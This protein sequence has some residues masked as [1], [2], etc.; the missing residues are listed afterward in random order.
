MSR[1]A[2]V[3]SIHGRRH[4]Q[5]VAVL[6]NGRA[7]GVTER[8]RR[9]I[10]RFVPEQD[11]FYS[12]S[13][14]E[15]RLVTRRI[16]DEGYDVV[17]AGGGD[18]TF[19]HCVNAL[20]EN[21]GDADR[22]TTP[23]GAALQLAPR[24][25]PRL[26]VLRL[27]TGN[28]LASLTGAGTGAVGAVED[29]L[30]V[31]SG[32]ARRTL[33]LHLLSADGTLTPFAGV[34]LD[35]R[36]LSDYVRLRD[37][38]ERTPLAMLGTGRAG[39]LLSVAGLSLPALLRQA[40]PNVTITNEGADAIQLGPDGRAVGRPIARG[41]VLYAGPARFCA[42][43]TEPYYGYGFAA[44]PHALKA[45]GFMQLR[46]TSLGVAQLVRHLPALWRGHTPSTGLLDF[47]IQ[48]VRLS[49]DRPVAS[50]VGGD[51]VPERREFVWEV[52]PEPV[53]LIDYRTRD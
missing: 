13:I 19:V 46:V 6:L 42:A 53:E 11:V 33:P 28:A 41:E 12:A 49:Y 20:L 29:I 10:A 4:P 38:L 2:S 47:H 43:G 8:L 44:F 1:L 15:A 50:Q 17:L 26:G 16:V 31:R 27:G 5:K 51:T 3:S 36:V 48:K 39:Y 25:R 22:T 37:G 14:P 23:G 34:G 32:D 40:D 9:E 24:R 18:G 45:P 7:L 21:L 52:A 30:R 35:A